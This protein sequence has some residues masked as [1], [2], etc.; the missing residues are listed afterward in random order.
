MK[1]RTKIGGMGLL[2]V[3]LTALSIVGIAL[4]QKNVLEE[5]IKIEVDQL[6]ESET[7]K[8]AQDVFLM[9]RTM[10]ESLEKRLERKLGVA[11]NVLDDTGQ[12]TFGQ[13]KVRWQAINQYTGLRKEVVLPKMLFGGQWLGQT[14]PFGDPVPIV[15]NV[16]SLLGSACTLFQRMNETGDMIRVAT[17]VPDSNK[18]RAVGTYI[19]RFNPDGTSNSVIERLLQGKVF[20]GRSYVVNDWYLTGYLPLLDRAG[21]KVIGAL[22]VGQREEGV[23]SLRRGIMDIRVGKTGYVA[24]LGAKGDQRGHYIISKRGQRDHENLL[25]PS[26]TARYSTTV[27]EIVQKALALENDSGAYGI[28]IQFHRYLWRNPG[29]DGLRPKMAAITYFEPWDWVILASAYEDDYRDARQR[30]A[31]AVAKMING[32]YWVALGIIVLSLAISFYIARGISKPLEKAVEVFGRIGRGELD[33][34]LRLDAGDEIG[35][36]SRAFDAMVGNLKQVTASRDE[37]DREIVRRTIVERELRETSARRKELEM[38]I[39][40]SSTVVFLWQATSGWPV[41]YVSR[42]IEQFGFQAE[43][44]QSGSRLFFSII[45]PEDVQQVAAEMARCEEKA[46]DFTLQYRL[47]DAEGEMCWVETRLWSRFDENG[48]VSHY[49]GVLLDVTDRK[50]A[51]EAVHKL[52]YYDTLTGLPNRTL[53]LDRLK[54]TLAQAKRDNRYVAL[55]FLDL[56]GFKEVNDLRGHAF[57]DLF[58]KAVGQRLDSCLRK[59][60]TLARFGGDEFVVLLP[61]VAET[62]EVR[63]VAIKILEAMNQPFTLESEMVKVTTSMGIAIFPL[64]GNDSGTLLKRADIAMYTAKGRGR[65]NFCFFDSGMDRG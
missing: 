5:N 22:F 25:D 44:F 21:K 20:T 8:V 39:N 63:S 37:L 65:N 53:L 4:H 52:A 24:V 10:H 23:A 38:I 16:S 58:L 18:D 32:V 46:N 19:P 48:R 59:N 12:V 31:G 29:D 33:V 57:G 62:P 40:H 1:I 43:E 55:L 9:C 35:Q 6:I 64:D 56:D 14:T 17:S 26:S 13:E 30:M 51:E 61:G 34:Q 60:D 47:I 27:E 49:Q 28:P 41:E 2:L 36:L 45:H 15:D 54:Q 11:K 42:N 7:K 3:I 50:K